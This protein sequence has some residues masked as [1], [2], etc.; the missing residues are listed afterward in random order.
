M[1][2]VISIYNQKGGVGKTTTTINLSAAL[3][4]TGLKKKKVLLV[5]MDPQ[6]NST[7]GLGIDKDELETTIYS[8]IN[9]ENEVNDTIVSTSCKNLFLIPSDS[10]LAGFEVEAVNRDDRTFLLKNI[11]EKV[12][13]SYDYIFIDCPPSLGLLS[14]NALCASDSVLVP[15]QTEY[16]ALEGVS[17]LI[18][19]ID[20]VKQGLNPSLEVEGVLLSMYDS[21]TKLGQDVVDEV[22]KHF[23][24]KVFNTVIPRNITLAE[25]PSY[26]ESVITYDKKSK[27]AQA[28]IELARE[29]KKNQK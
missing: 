13:N 7:S 8:I 9:G 27:G 22:T 16:Y 20:M 21:R 25:A 1:G 11:I 29:F 18:S 23:G 5:D 24:N 3:A 15:I 19:T 12:K 10:D 2:K 17:Q 28:Y 14:L 4:S 6:G 26:G